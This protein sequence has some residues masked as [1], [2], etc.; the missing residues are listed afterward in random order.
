M[1]QDD[2]ND[3]M[4]CFR[5]DLNQSCLHFIDGL[6]G[7]ELLRASLADC[8]VLGIDTETKPTYIPKEIRRKAF[9]KTA[10]V[11]M[12]TRSSSGCE[13]VFVVDML[14][15]AKAGCLE[16]LDGI[17]A[18][19]LRD[20][21]CIKVGQSLAND[22]KEL[23][24]SYPALRSFQLICSVADTT[25]LIKVLQ[26][27]LKQPLSLKNLVKQYLHFNLVKRQQMSDWS[28]RPLT[29]AQLH[30]AACD[31]LV[32]LRL[33]DA[34]VCEAEEM[35]GEQGRV[36]SVSSW[37]D[38]VDH[39]PGQR[40]EVDSL[41]SDATDKSDCSEMDD[42][43]AQAAGSRRKRKRKKGRPEPY[44]PAKRPHIVSVQSGVHVRY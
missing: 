12:A 17:L 43:H 1:G 25:A 22:F 44:Q 41:S 14:T 33:Y 18:P 31:A 10:L 23:R 7:L 27:E 34:M 9:N 2:E 16:A 20:E 36:F 13:E 6:A 5:F 26:P 3:K 37:A 19:V 40:A 42:A 39:R 28:R 24:M 29:S 11:Q 30:Y 38:C 21:R 15:L 35:H 32:L 4:L 8:V